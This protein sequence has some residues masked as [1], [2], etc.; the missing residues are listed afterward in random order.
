MGVSD[1]KRYWKYINQKYVDMKHKNINKY[2]VL[3]VRVN[4]IGFGEVLNDPI[5]AKPFECYTKTFIGFGA[6]DNQENAVH[7]LKYI[8][9]K[10]TRTMLGVLKVTQQNNKDTWAMVPLQ[11]FTDKS[12][13]DWSKSIHEIDLQLY[14]KYGLD[15][16]EIDF[17]E[18]HVKEMK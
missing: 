8:K 15:Q 17:I 14:K 3:V 1:N 4:A 5:V 10:F 11:D 6:E 16:N 13:I 7:I 2:K 18:S 9:S 12:D